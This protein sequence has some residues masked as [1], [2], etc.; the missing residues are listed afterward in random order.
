MNAYYHARSSARKWGGDPLAYLPVH[1]FLDSSKSAWADVRHRALLHSSWG[2]YLAQQV[3]GPVLTVP[4]EHRDVNVP[5]RLI[6]ERHVLEDLG[7][8][9][10][11]GDYLAE[12]T[13]QPWMSGAKTRT[14]PMSEFLQG[15]KQ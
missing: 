11:P 6:A 5:V 4:R 14:V 13:I 15:G 2:I 8:I 7:R 1:E 9:P 10:P 12:M 3:F